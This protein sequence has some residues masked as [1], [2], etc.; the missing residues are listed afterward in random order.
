ML[1]QV[2][3]TG[4]RPSDSSFL[5][6]LFFF[7]RNITYFDNFE[8]NKNSN[9]FGWQVAHAKRITFYRQLKAYSAQLLYSR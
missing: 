8:I 4:I 2:H 5:A 9:R 3:D 7:I 1:L 6:K